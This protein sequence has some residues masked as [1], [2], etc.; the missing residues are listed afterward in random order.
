MKRSTRL[1]DLDAMRSILM[2]LGVVLHS[3]NPYRADTTWLVRDAHTTS[4]LTPL[5][6]F[7]HFFR[8]PAFFA[9][10]GYFA[11]YT[12]VSRPVPAYL[13][14]RLTRLLLPFLAALVCLNI[15]QVWLLLDSP[16]TVSGFA[17]SLHATW[18]DGLLVG[19]LWFLLVLSIHCIVLAILADATRRIADSRRPD[20]LASATG[21]PLLT[22]AGAVVLTG[23]TSLD[24][25]APAW[26][27]QPFLGLV[28][29]MEVLTYSV[30]FAIGVLLYGRAEL[31]TRFGQ[32]QPVEWLVLG[33]IAMVL[34][35]PHDGSLLWRAA[36]VFATWWLMVYAVRLCFGAFRKWASSE[37]AAFRYL[38][39]ASYTVYLFHHLIVV[40]LSTLLLDLA[41]PALLK[42]A[43]VASVTAVVTLLI[44]EHVI[45]RSP[46]L[47][48]WFNGT[49]KPLQQK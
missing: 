49:R 19:H 4:V 45:L 41:W 1:H 3:A 24:Y 5:V 30:F 22:A 10:A 25:L 20:S 29:P 9:V 28:D 36:E 37:S 7:I 43:A 17:A 26:M 34:L 12:I 8:M 18:V 16:R 31:L 6:D 42:F 21:L 47:R 35:L 23:M 44:H 39:D 27:H 38:S 33:A 14:E 11:T 48:L 13:K 40:L 2:M 46:L 15:P 32:V